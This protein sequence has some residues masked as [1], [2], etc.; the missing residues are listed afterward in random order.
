MLNFWQ[1]TAVLWVV[2][3][4]PNQHSILLLFIWTKFLPWFYLEVVEI[5]ILFNSFCSFNF[6]INYF[7]I[8]K[9]IRFQYNNKQ[10]SLSHCH[11]K[12]FVY[13]WFSLRFYLY[14]RRKGRKQKFNTQMKRSKKSLFFVKERSTKV[15]SMSVQVC[16]YP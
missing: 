8:N 11:L 6:F 14:N 12:H 16:L 10:S 5:L 2:G 3:T 13:K 1:K 9:R 4:L 7:M 15:H